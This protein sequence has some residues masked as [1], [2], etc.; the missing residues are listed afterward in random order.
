MNDETSY[1]NQDLITNNPFTPR[2]QVTPEG[3]PVPNKFALPKD[4]K[5]RLLIIL[6]VV[7]VFLLLL[8]T[9]ITTVRQSTRNTTPVKVA[10]VTSAPQPTD[11]PNTSNFPQDLKDQ[12]DAADKNTQKQVDFAP[13][14]IDNSIGL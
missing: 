7:V 8:R 12:F 1:Q 4:P 11:I 3:T 9:I 13:P 14:Q 2:G 5:I 10:Q 6:S